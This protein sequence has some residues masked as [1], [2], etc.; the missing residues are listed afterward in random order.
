MFRISS[1]F[2]ALTLAACF[3][4]AVVWVSHV[5]PNP[6]QTKPCRAQPRACGV[7]RL[8][9]IPKKLLSD[10]TGNN[11]HYIPYLAQVASKLFGTAVVSVDDQVFEIGDVKYSFSIQ[12]ISRA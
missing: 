2:K 5:C 9:G 11:A 7:S 3:L 8:R 12:S 4:V 6:N 10:T 1:R